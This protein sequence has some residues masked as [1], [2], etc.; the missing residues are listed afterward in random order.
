[1]ITIDL[2]DKSAL[3]TGGTKGIGLAI[4]LELARA[5]ARVYLTYRWGTADTAALY[6]AFEAINAH[7]PVL[8]EADVSSDQDTD[9]LMTRIAAVEKKID[10]FISNA[11]TALLTDSLEAYKKKSLFKTLE[12]SSWP[13]IEYSKKINAQFGAYPGYIIGISSDGPD[14]FYQG[15]DFV[16]ASKALLEVFSRYLSV[17]LSNLG[18]RVN[19]VRFGTVRTDSFDA[20]FGDDFF[21]YIK[22]H[23]ITGD[24][25]L[26]LSD[27][28]KT[29]AALCSGLLD[30]VNGQVITAD[31]GL[32]FR[33]NIMMNYLHSKQILKGGTRESGAEQGPHR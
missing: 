23:G 21:D 3:I 30:A 6:K 32:A 5:G 29:V 7:K 27:C 25:L 13:M 8:L 20:V 24:M 15:Y 26:K 22:T 28:G 14:H 4:A 18:T 33:S 10:I 17:H 19:V 31:N 11:S 2:S 12:F 1:M 16:A 9:A